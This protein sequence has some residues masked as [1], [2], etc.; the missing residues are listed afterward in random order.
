MASI[1]PFDSFL[2]TSLRKKLFKSYHSFEILSEADLQAFVWMHAKRFLRK[3]PAGASKFRVVNKLFCGDLKIH[4]DLV[5]LRRDKPWICLELKEVGRIGPAAIGEDWSRLNKTRGKL[6][7]H[8]G[9]LIYLVRH[10][11][12]HFPKPRD[13]PKIENRSSCLIPI[14]VSMEDRL[15]AE[16]FAS[17]NA[18]F[19]RLSKYR[20]PLKALG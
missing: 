17:W 6:K 14:V 12:R 11:I 4:P 7:A 5:V 10:S 16:E 13:F 9:Y 18:K 2:Q 19:K 20:M 3:L 15:P 8:R 1:M